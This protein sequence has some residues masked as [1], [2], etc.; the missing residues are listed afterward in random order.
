MRR[1]SKL[2]LAIIFAAASFCSAQ[3]L[4]VN[5]GFEL[6][7]DTDGSWPSSYGDWQ[8]DYSS[9]VGTTSGITAYE[10]SQMLQLKGTSWTTF[11]SSAGAC[12]VPQIVDVSQYASLIA[13]GDAVVS[14]SVYLNRVTGDAQTD[15]Q[16]G[17]SIYA[18]EGSAG[19]YPSDR[20][21]HLWL[22]REVAT[23]YTD[24]DPGTWQLCEL[25]VALPTNTDYVV[26]E[27]QGSENI[28]NDTSYPEFDGHF[29]DAVSVQIIP[30]PATLILLGTGTLILIRKY[31]KS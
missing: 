10:G 23:I 28:F 26:I 20:A 1:K 2:L 15:N 22:L 24:A 21:N 30:E 25:Q 3:N 6:T 5:S 13:S 19:S 29:A 9:I 8:G 16:L 7:E 31:Q 11:P 12:E 17:I 18:H 27:L 4:V 14:A